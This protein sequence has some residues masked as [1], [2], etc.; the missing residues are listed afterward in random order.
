MVDDFAGDKSFMFGKST[1]NQRMEAWWGR[2]IQGCADWWME[3]FKDFVGANFFPFVF[4]FLTYSFRCILFLL[5][6]VFR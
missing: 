4:R 3:F 2:L 5:A 6:P 1:S